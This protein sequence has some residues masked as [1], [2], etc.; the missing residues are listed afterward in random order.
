[1]ATPQTITHHALHQQLQGTYTALCHRVT[2]EIMNSRHLGLPS[3]S[4]DFVKQTYQT[5]NTHI[6]QCALNLRKESRRLYDGLSSEIF[7]GHEEEHTNLHTDMHNTLESITNLESAFSC[8]LKLNRLYDTYNLAKTPQGEVVTQLITRLN[9]AL[10]NHVSA[11]VNASC[12]EHI[13]EFRS[14]ITMAAEQMTQQLITSPAA[15]HYDHLQ[16]SLTLLRENEKSLRYEL[17]RAEHQMMLTINSELEANLA[18]QQK[19]NAELGGDHVDIFKNPKEAAFFI[20]L[21]GSDT[22]TYLKELVPDM[23]LEKTEIDENNFVGSILGRFCILNTQT[24]GMANT[25]KIFDDMCKKLNALLPL[26]KPG[27]VNIYMMPPPKPAAPDDKKASLQIPAGCHM[28]H[29]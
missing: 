24:H 1:M 10:R 4:T 14:T 3:R 22:D 29:G 13:R 19:L 20:A 5:C 8:L 26:P 17:E 12:R 16:Q 9:T 23:K 15:Q 6:Q 18:A 11:I 7:T 25:Q 21:Y 27:Q 2:E 28:T